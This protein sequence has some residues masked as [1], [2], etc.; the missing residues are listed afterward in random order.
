MDI[1]E[2]CLLLGHPHSLLLS[3]KRGVSRPVVGCN[4]TSIICKSNNRLVARNAL[5]PFAAL[6]CKRA[7]KPLTVLN[8]P[9]STF[10]RLDDIFIVVWYIVRTIARV[11]TLQA[12]PRR[13]RL[14]F[15][16]VSCV[17]FIIWVFFKPQP[18]NVF[19]VRRPLRVP[20]THCPDGIIVRGGFFQELGS[21]RRI[22]GRSRKKKK[23]RR[24]WAKST[25][26]RTESQQRFFGSFFFLV[27]S[28]FLGKKTKQL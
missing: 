22:Y 11:R 26:S 3:H 12:K 8:V 7:S 10:V 15:R 2:N 9:F 16:S 27:I 4:C 23:T 21:E 14:T 1:Y 6:S 28:F 18:K 20:S 13:V 25:P 17:I 5:T 24:K 19:Q